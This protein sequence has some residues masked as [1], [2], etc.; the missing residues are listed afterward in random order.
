MEDTWLPSQ[1][2]LYT[3]K[4][5]NTLQSL[6]R[7]PNTHTNLK[8]ARGKTRSYLQMN[9]NK[10]ATVFKAEVIETRNNGMTSLKC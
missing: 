2:V 7:K 4:W 8:M 1:E 10:S 9:S 6:T 5:I 3:P